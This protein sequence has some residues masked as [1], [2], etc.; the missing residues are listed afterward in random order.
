MVLPIGI[1]RSVAS[2]VAITNAVELV[3]GTPFVEPP[4]R[5]DGRGSNAKQL[6]GNDVSLSV[7]CYLE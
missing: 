7:S 1:L 6:P 3:E 2:L 4:Q 5:L